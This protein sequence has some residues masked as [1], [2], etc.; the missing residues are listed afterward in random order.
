MRIAVVGAGP[1]GLMAAQRLS[2]AGADVA[3]FDKGRRPG[4]RMNTREHGHF[5]FD[6][7]A[8]FFTVRDP[9]VRVMLLKWLEQ[10]VVRPWP[11]RLVRIS[12]PTREPAHR[13]ERYV[14]TPKMISVPEHLALALDVRSGTRVESVDRAERSLLLHDDEGV[15]LGRF[16]RVVIAVPSPQAVSL[17]SAAPRIQRVARSVRMEP[18]WAVMLVFE[19]RPELEFDGAFVS[20]GGVSWI[21]R[22]ASKPAR[23]TSEAWVVHAS[24][25]WTRR[26]WKVEPDRIPTLLLKVVESQFGGMPP[27]VFE[28]AHRWGYA[29]ARER[30]P[31]GLYDET[32]GISAAGDWCVGGR[33]EGALISGI[34][35]AERILA[36]A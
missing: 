29:L 14:G 34:E 8:Q 5:S 21:A 10:G 12:G 25:E 33:V 27:V 13:A 23:T 16:D 3:V 9:R 1:A 31:G 15:E 24:S 11:G 18:C 28:R 32:S 2:E 26:H 17:L 19:R 22:D 36:S 7:G 20:G 6:H 4:G 35:A 30:G